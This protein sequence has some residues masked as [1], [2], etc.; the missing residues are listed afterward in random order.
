MSAERR[1]HERFELLAQV[2]LHRGGQLE[3][4]TVLNVSAG[5][6][7]LRNDH[8]VEL[9]LGEVI[10]VHFDVPQL[11]LAFA[12]DAR[13]IR[14]VAPTAKPPALAAM[15]SSSDAAASAGLAQLLWSLSGSR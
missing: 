8:D 1:H 13:V 11:S 6:L 4:L 3:T 15:W 5:G 2:E 10:R 9:V 14:I 12:I 7:L